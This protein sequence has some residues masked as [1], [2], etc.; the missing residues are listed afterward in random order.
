MRDSINF[1]K[2]PNSRRRDGGD[3]ENFLTSTTPAFGLRSSAAQLSKLIFCAEEREYFT[4]AYCPPESGGQRHRMFYPM[5]RGVVPKP[6]RIVLE[7][8][9]VS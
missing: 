8:P 2:L 7:P 6:R 5:P 3:Q 9:L 4:W 1:A